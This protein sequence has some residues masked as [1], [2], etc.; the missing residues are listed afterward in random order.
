MLNKRPLLL[1]ERENRTNNKKLSD[2]MMRL[3]R[4]YV[5]ELEDTRRYPLYQPPVF[6]S[7][8]QNYAESTSGYPYDKGTKLIK[9]NDKKGGF[10]P[11]LGMMAAPM[12]G[13]LIG[14]IFGG[15]KLNKKDIENINDD[16]QGSGI[17]SSLLG[18][19]GLGKKIHNR[20][21]LTKEE[22]KVAEMDEKEGGFLPLLLGS[23]AAPLLG[24]LFGGKKLPKSDMEGGII[25]E[26]IGDM[27]G[28]LFKRGAQ[29]LPKM[30]MN[31]GKRYLNEVVDKTKQ[32]FQQ[33]G[34][35][36]LH[37]GIDI[38]KDKAIDVIRDVLPPKS[39]GKKLTKK[40]LIEA[41]TSTKSGGRKNTANKW[42]NFLQSK[43]LN[44]RTMPKKGTKEYNK[45]MS[46]YKK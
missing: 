34:S 30:A 4:E 23:L 35:D 8:I 36:I 10:L 1:L 12:I 11:I 28:T 38:V 27:M 43:N 20:D 14:K 39:G 32:T 19:I 16:M 22:I 9:Q 3:N 2:D 29:M 45:L 18:M 13:N 41:M 31:L 42:I 15:K 37:R 33:H 17:F 5:K 6:A 24:K 40:Q 46:E 7:D 25:G 44:P 21:K 26:L